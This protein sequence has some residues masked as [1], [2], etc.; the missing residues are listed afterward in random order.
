MGSNSSRD[1]RPDKVDWSLP[2]FRQGDFE[3]VFVCGVPLTI[4]GNEVGV[5]LDL[6]YKIRCGDVTF[7]ELHQGDILLRYRGSVPRHISGL[8]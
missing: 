6:I 1:V 4:L 2:V 8:I 7:G 5:V 3:F